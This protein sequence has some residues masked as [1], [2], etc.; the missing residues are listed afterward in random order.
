M[1]FS[2]RGS[3]FELDVDVTV[4]THTTGLKPALTR[5][6]GSVRSDQI[7]CSL[8]RVLVCD[9]LA[10]VFSATCALSSTGGRVAM[11]RSNAMATAGGAALCMSSSASAA[12]M[13]AGPST[14]VTGM[15]PGPFQVGVTTMQ[16]DDLSRKCPS[17]SVMHVPSA[18]THLRTPTHSFTNTCNPST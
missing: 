5:R 6:G 3:C 4:K 1:K 14:S 17:R 9:M 13:N 15:A 11:R 8:V 2:R 18:R 16:F 7:R 10:T 12:G